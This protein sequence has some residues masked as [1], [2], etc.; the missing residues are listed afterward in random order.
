MSKLSVVIGKLVDT[1]CPHHT[2]IDGGASFVPGSST[3]RD[4]TPENLHQ[5]RDELIAAL[6]LP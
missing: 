2:E 5:L 3:L 1:V 6:E 4:P